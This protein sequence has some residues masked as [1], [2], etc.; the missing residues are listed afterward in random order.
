MAPNYHGQPTVVI[1]DVPEGES[2][3]PEVRIKVNGP[4]DVTVTMGDVSIS[5]VLFQK[6]SRDAAGLVTAE[7][8]IG[9]NPVR[10]DMSTL[11]EQLARA[12]KWPLPDGVPFTVEATPDGIELTVDG[13]KVPL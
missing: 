9:P 5:G 10:L 8:I 12:G 1:T 6:I 2:T 11:G 3:L 4:D 13:V 7:T